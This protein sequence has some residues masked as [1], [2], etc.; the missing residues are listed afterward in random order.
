MENAIQ[1]NPTHENYSH[2]LYVFIDCIPS[3][4]TPSVINQEIYKIINEKN[5]LNQINGFDVNIKWKWNSIK[6][7]YYTDVEG[8]YG[9]VAVK[10]HTDLLILHIKTT[11]NTHFSTEDIRLTFRLSRPL[12]RQYPLL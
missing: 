9:D 4:I 5:I 2:L 8:F 3:Y 12:V 7:C 10:K 11:L 6:E 1:N